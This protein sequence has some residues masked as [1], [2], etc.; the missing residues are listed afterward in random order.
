MKF[1]LKYYDKKLTTEVEYYKN[2]KVLSTKRFFIKQGRFQRENSMEFRG[3]D[4]LSLKA[5]QW[6]FHQY[7]YQ[8]EDVDRLSALLNQRARQDPLFLSPA[9][10]Q[11]LS[12]LNDRIVTLSRPRAQ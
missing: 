4:P 8:S 10:S 7:E 5:D 11:A 6:A 3:K 2:Q 1:L 12:Q 9:P